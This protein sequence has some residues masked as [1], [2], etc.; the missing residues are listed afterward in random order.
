MQ[1]FSSNVSSLQRPGS[2]MVQ[3]LKDT[4]SLKNML[5]SNLTSLFYNLK[6]IF[7]LSKKQIISK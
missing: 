3:G 4:R 2:S 6:T 1:V 7:A 5:E